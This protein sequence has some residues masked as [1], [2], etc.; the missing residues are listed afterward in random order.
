MHIYSCVSS[1]IMGI[2]KFDLSKN[3]IILISRDPFL[4]TTKAIVL[5]Q[6]DTSH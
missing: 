6:I 4:K 3:Y 1:H 5:P 2:Q